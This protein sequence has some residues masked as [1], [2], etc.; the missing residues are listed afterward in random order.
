MSETAL[1]RTFA[2]ATI[3]WASALIL[4]PFIASRSQV[5]S[6]AYVVSLAIYKVGS[7]IC[8]QR[9]ERSFHAWGAQLPVCARCAG[10]YLGA[11]VA[12]VGAAT[13]PAHSDRDPVVKRAMLAV[14]LAALPTALTLFDEWTTGLTPANWIR[15]VAGFPLGA[16]VAWVI[17]VASTPRTAVAIH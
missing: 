12:A 4:G 17:V 7:L 10:I 8:H 6:L 3:V 5:G 13:M 11:L 16:I 15:S 14:M 9:P 2:A 1:R